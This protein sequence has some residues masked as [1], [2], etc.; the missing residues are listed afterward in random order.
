[1]EFSGTW[2][3][4][5]LVFQEVKIV[6]SKA[7]DGM[8]W[9]VKKGK[10]HLLISGKEW[11]LEGVWSGNTTFSSCTPGRVYLKKIEPRA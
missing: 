4:E 2:D 1:M 11:R 6:R 5:N 3:G 10:L 8:E 7:E 9:C